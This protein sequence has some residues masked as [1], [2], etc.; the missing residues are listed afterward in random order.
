ML[1]NTKNYFLPPLEKLE[2]YNLGTDE[3]EPI[4]QYWFDY[5]SNEVTSISN[6]TQGILLFLYPYFFMILN[7]FL[8]GNIIGI[9]LKKKIQKHNKKLNYTLLTIITFLII[10]FC[11]SVFATINVF[12]YQ[13]FPLIVTI[14][15][16]LI[17]EWI[18]RP[19]IQKNSKG[20]IFEKE[21]KILELETA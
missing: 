7:I 16:I 15:L 14:S 2:E 12:R 18:D 3:V 6:K 21:N 8:I 13:V 11:F 9:L 10:N 4:A 5:K 1:L 19:V 17:I 20:L